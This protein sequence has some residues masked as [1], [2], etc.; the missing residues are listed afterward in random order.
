MRRLAMPAWATVEV[1]TLPSPAQFEEKVKLRKQA[2]EEVTTMNNKRRPWFP[3]SEQALAHEPYPIPNLSEKGVA[4]G[5]EVVERLMVDHSGFGTEN[6][7]AMTQAAFV[8]R[9]KGDIRDGKKYGYAITDVG[10]FQLYV[11]VF[12]KA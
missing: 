9:L 7:P 11:T 5:Y 2:I 4:D 6:E 1:G 12:T 3:K 10:Q 8:Q